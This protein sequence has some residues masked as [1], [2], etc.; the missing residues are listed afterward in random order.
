MRCTPATTC[1]S[2]LLVFNPVHER[3]MAG[4]AETEQAWAEVAWRCRLSPAEVRMA[5]ELG[6]KPRSLLKNILSPQQPWKA[7][8][9]EWVRELHQKRLRRA[10]QRRRRRERGASPVRPERRPEP[11]GVTSFAGGE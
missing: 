10:D 4:K 9:T 2:R 6:F 7:P 8:V 3:V 5:R 11:R 1:M